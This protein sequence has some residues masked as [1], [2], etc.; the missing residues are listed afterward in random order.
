LT[1]TL[2]LEPGTYLLR[3]QFA[4]GAHRAL[5]GE[6]YRAE[7]QIVVAENAPA[8]QVIFVKPGD[9]ATVTSPFLVGWAAS[10][11]IIEAAGKSIRP[12]GGHLHLLIDQDFVATGEVIPV[13]ETHLHFGKGQTSTELTLEPGEHTLRLQMANGGH[14]AQDGEQ[15]RDEITITVK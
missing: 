15:Y 2:T 4:D 10:G 1:T 5:S 12:Q 7:A 6:Q 8:E 11:L 3:L 14:I 9:G 13:D